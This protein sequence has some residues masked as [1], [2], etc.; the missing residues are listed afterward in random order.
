M[1]QRDRDRE[2][3]RQ[4]ETERHR[5]R[6]Q[7]ETNTQK[8]KERKKRKKKRRRDLKG[9]SPTSRNLC[10]EEPMTMTR[11]KT[12]LLMTGADQAPTGSVWH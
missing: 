8:R 12:L 4:R 2:R 6:E 11:M 3:Q 5:E 10:P 1:R 7:N 9:S